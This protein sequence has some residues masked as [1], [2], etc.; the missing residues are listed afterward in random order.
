[1]IVMK[2]Y[3]VFILVSTLFLSCDFE[4]NIQDNEAVISLDDVQLPEISEQEVVKEKE[5]AEALPP[6][7]PVS[8]AKEKQRNEFRAKSPFLNLGCC[9][10]EAKQI[11]KCCCEVVLKKYK[12]MVDAN[13]PKLADYNMKDPILSKCKRILI[14]QFDLIDNPPSLDGDEEEDPWL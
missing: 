8:E 5:L 1:M 4:E 9:E 14:K 10:D 6:P 12:I 3:L 2:K 7:P 13:D 11:E